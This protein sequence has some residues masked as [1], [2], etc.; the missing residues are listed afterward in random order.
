MGH[1]VVRGVARVRIVS[2]GA[3]ERPVDSCGVLSDT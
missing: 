1:H 2:R 3:Y